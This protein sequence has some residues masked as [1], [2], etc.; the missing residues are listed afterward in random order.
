MLAGHGASGVSGGNGTP[1]QTMATPVVLYVVTSLSQHCASHVGKRFPCVIRRV[2]GS[3]LGPHAG[4]AHNSCPSTYA[5]P[6]VVEAQVLRRVASLGVLVTLRYHMQYE[7][8]MAQGMSLATAFSNSVDVQTRAFPRLC[9][10]PAARLPLH[11][12][13]QDVV[14]TC[15]ACHLPMQQILNGGPDIPI[16]M[17]S[18][19]SIPLSNANLT[20]GICRSSL[21]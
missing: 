3:N 17:V 20:K 6:S 10:I 14:L 15:A 21:C 7:I 5:A 19:P 11:S 16:S 13:R 1:W 9:L 4:R 12:I 8:P 18:S 2:S